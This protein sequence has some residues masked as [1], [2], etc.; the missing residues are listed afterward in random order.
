MDHKAQLCKNFVNMKSQRVRFE[1]SFAPALDDESE[2]IEHLLAEPKTEFVTVDGVLCFGKENVEK[3]LSFDDFASGFDYGLNTF[4]GGRHSAHPRGLRSAHPRQG[5]YELELGVLDG[6]LDEVEEVEDIHATNGLA[7]PCDDFLLDIGFTG[8]DTVLEFGPHERSHCGN[9]DSRSPGLS[10][11]SNSVVGVS[12]SSTVTIQDFECKNHSQPKESPHKFLCDLRQKKRRQTPVE[13]STQPS[14][15]SFQNL[16][17]LDNYRKPL[18]NGLCSSEI[19]KSSVEANKIGAIIKKRRLP[20]TKRFVE[21]SS[22]RKAKNFVASDNIS[23]PAA[24]D[25]QC[26]HARSQSKL[27]TRPRTLSSVPEEDS[28]SDNLTLSEFKIRIAR[29]KK[30][31][32]PTEFQPITSESEDEI[33]RVTIREKHDQGNNQ[34]IKSKSEDETLTTKLSKKHDRRKHQPTNSESANETATRRRSTRN[35]QRTHHPVNSESD[36]EILERKRS[37]KHDRRKHQRMWDISEV[38]ALV[39]GISEHGVAQWTRIQRLLF[40]SFSHRTPMDLRVY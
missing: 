18:G 33:V 27:L 9:T 22:K 24:T 7:S 32:I 34:P 2:T 19:D 1:E 40:T 28:I 26:S 10:G 4:T 35:N 6:L 17:E 30:Q 21:N 14:S 37:K 5:D 16:K 20:K 15:F 36:D 3:C 13:G 39:D 38:M 23:H 29:P 25:D 31:A 11:S 12:E 8:K